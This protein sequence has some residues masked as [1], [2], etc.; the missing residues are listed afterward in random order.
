MDVI[1]DKFLQALDFHISAI[2][3][4]EKG[5]LRFINI[6]NLKLNAEPA[7]VD[8]LGQVVMNFKEEVVK[9]KNKCITKKKSGS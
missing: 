5:S 2:G 9:K 4:F 6:T 1:V 8:N 7:V 3:Y